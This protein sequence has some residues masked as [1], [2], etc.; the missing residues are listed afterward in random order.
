MSAAEYFTYCSAR[1]ISTTKRK[2]GTKTKLIVVKLLQND[3]DLFRCD[4]CGRNGFWNRTNK[5]NKTERICFIHPEAQNMH[6]NDE[7]EIKR[8]K[9]KHDDHVGVIFETSNTNFD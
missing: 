2:N 5:T 8:K 3:A 7:T 9:N 4:L 1:N 6:E